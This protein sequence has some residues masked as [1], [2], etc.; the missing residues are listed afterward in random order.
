MEIVQTGCMWLA[1]GGY[2]GKKESYL[3]FEAILTDIRTIL[4]QNGVPG[5]GNQI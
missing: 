1:T 2:S 5:I 3:G 4:S